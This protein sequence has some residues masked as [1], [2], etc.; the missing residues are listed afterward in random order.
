MLT[1]A[2]ALA[3]N[4]LP[5]CPGTNVYSNECAIFYPSDSNPLPTGGSFLGCPDG[6]TL[7]YDFMN[8]VKCAKGELIEPIAK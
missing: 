1:L 7:V 4:T 3:M 2:L 6:Y 5:Q 8:Q